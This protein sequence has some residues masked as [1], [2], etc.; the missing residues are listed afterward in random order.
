MT[1]Q[2]T[3]YLLSHAISSPLSPQ[4]QKACELALDFW[5]QGKWVLLWCENKA[6]AERLDDALW[7][8]EEAFI[9]HNLAGELTQSPTPLE[10]AWAGKRNRQGRDVVINL[11]IKVPEFIHSFQK[12]VDFVPLSEAEKTLARERYKHYRQLGWQLTIEKS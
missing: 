8:T 11:A 10:I 12:A 1:S 6:Q 5:R 2:V 7:Q 3:F 9:P 4:E